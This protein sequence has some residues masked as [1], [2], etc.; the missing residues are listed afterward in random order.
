MKGRDTED[1]WG[2][3]MEERWSVEIDAKAGSLA[4]DFSYCHLQT[5]G[6]YLRAYPFKALQVFTYNSL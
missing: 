6:E 3:G 5:F 2:A 4:V 1:G